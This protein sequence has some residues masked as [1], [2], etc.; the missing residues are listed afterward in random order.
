MMTD[1]GGA[2]MSEPFIIGETIKTIDGPFN[3][4]MVLLKR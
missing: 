1:L 3:I 4:S 2:A